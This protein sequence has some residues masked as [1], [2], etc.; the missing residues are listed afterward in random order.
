[1]TCTKI[2]PTTSTGTTGNNH[3][4]NHEIHKSS[5]PFLPALLLLCSALWSGTP[6][7]AQSPSV[8]V[9]AEWEPHAA[10]WMQW[11][12]PWESELRPEFAAI[13]DII[14]RYEPVHLV[15]ADLVQQN[16]AR[17]F[18][19]AR[20]VPMTQI[21]WHVI[22]TDNSWMRDNGPVYVTDGRE[23][24][25]QDWKFDAWGGNFGAEI[26]SAADDAVPAAVADYLGL[27]L[28][29]NSD[30]VLE[31]GN[32]EFNGDGILVLNWDCQDDR[33]PGMTRAEH[34]AV[35]TEAFGLKQ[36]IWAYGYYPED[37]TTGHIDGIAR[38]VSRDTLAVADYGSAIENDLAVAAQ[39]AGLKVVWYPGDPNW[40]VGNGFV[41]AMSSGDSAEDA[42]LRGLLESWFP[43]RD[44]HMIDA[45]NIAAGGGGI[46][47]VTNDQPADA[48]FL[49]GDGFESGGLGA[50]QED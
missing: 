23:T 44:V 37:G 50:W 17:Q 10:T 20:G 43:G 13:I 34:E 15:A 8:R 29:N 6:M 27:D 24:W 42:N 5:L 3:E 46:H 9:P 32:L 22:P 28:E 49:F 35:L 30:Y 38:F 36:I 18:L 48:G 19:I 33:N 11:P 47:C 41:A 39:A 1:M 12:G 2:F 7:S 25:I 40:L 14:Q 26:P 45:S 21:T 4:P 16:Q 31:K